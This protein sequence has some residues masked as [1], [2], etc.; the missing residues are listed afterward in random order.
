LIPEVPKKVHDE[1]TKTVRYTHAARQR[2]QSLLAATQRAVEIAIEDS[3][4][5]A[6]AYLKDKTV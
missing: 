3:E 5:A 1:I 6:L 4:S 2:A